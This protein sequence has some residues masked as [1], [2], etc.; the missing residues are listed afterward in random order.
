MRDLPF[1]LIV[2]PAR[3]D[4]QSDSLVACKLLFKRIS[5]FHFLQSIIRVCRV[6]EIVMFFLACVCVSARLCERVSECV[7]LIFEGEG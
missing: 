2:P 1:D 7:Y 4:Y 5:F 3:D 6:P